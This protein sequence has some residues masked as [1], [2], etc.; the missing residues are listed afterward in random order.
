M[1]NNSVDWL[2]LVGVPHDLAGGSF[3]AKL[4]IFIRLS[5]HFYVPVFHFAFKALLRRN[6]RSWYIQLE[7]L[8]SAL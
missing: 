8:T 2:N 1:R 6:L 5:L 7:L 3:S 4:G